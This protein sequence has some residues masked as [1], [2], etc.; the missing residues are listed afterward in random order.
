MGRSEAWAW[1]IKPCKSVTRM[2]ALCRKR[3]EDFLD[4]P[5][6]VLGKSLVPI[7]SK[8]VAWLM[9]SSTRISARLQQERQNGC[10]DRVH[11]S[12]WVSRHQ[13][14]LF[15]NSREARLCIKEFWVRKMSSQCRE[16]F[17]RASLFILCL[18]RWR[19]IKSNCVVWDRQLALLE[20]FAA[21][22]HTLMIHQ[23]A[24]QKQGQLLFVSF[25]II[26][27]LPLI[28][29]HWRAEL[30]QTQCPRFHKHPNHCSLTFE[31]LRFLLLHHAKLM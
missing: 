7:R 17:T 3:H 22:Q 23:K 19:S 5:P 15:C 13:L 16:R 20:H 4:N 10:R 2:E 12:S 6:R 18:R 27:L 11:R 30:R 25:Q 24:A 1:W 21:L 26:I 31:C 8:G 9:Q 29:V 28:M 14:N